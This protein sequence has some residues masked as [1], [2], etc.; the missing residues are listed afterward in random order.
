MSGR[1]SAG[2]VVELS[3]SLTSLR[4]RIAE[5]SSKVKDGMQREYLRVAARAEELR[6]SL[7]EV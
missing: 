5:I 3:E 1:L 2:E 4:Q 7:G 6:A